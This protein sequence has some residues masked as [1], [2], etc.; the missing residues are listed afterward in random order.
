MGRKSKF[1]SFT[2][3]A[4]AMALLAL[5]ATAALAQ[6]PTPP[7]DGVSCTDAEPGG[8]SDC[9][10]GGAAAGEVL[11]WTA[12]SEGDEFASGTATADETGSAFFSIDIPT[13]VLGEV[14]VQVTGD[15]GFEAETTIDAEADEDEGTPVSEEG[16]S[17]DTDEDTLPI[18]G[19]QIAL[20]LALAVGLIAVGTVAARKKDKAT[21]QA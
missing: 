3:L 15:E 14:L 17:D 5:S 4:S 11:N 21:T 20:L 8:T 9:A 2:V 13:D 19:G 18:T 10:V 7:E 12:S 16:A 1:R 6:Y